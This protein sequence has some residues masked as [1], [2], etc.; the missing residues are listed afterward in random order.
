[1]FVLSSN[2]ITAE[3]KNKEKINS[4]DMNT[5]YEI[6]G[7]LGFPLGQL[8]DIKAKVLPNPGKGFSF[9]GLYAQRA[10][11]RRHIQVP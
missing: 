10:G 2:F 4:S 7:P 9:Q 5:K 6:I 8:I 11:H 3:E 1:M